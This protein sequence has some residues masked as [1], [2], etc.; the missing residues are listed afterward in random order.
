MALVS[1]LLTGCNGLS[2]M[3]SNAG[4][5]R[6][7]ANPNPV[8]T[9]DEKV[10][11]KFT[12]QVPQKYFD[13]G[14]VMFIQPVFSWEGGNIPLEPLTLKGEKVDGDGTIINYA[15]GGRFT[16]SDMFDF[17][18]GMETGRVTLTPVGYSAR[19]TNEDARFADDILRDNNGKEFSPVLISDGVNNT[20]SMVDIKGNISISPINYNKTQG[21]VEAADIYFNGGTSELDWNFA[22][23]Q[24]FDSYNTLQQLKRIMLEQ[25]LPKQISITGW[26]SPEGEET[27]NVGVSKNRADVA[28]AQLN[29]VLDE[30]LTIMA[31]RAKVKPQDVDYYKYEQLKKLVITTRAAGEDWVH[32]VVMVEASDI[33]DKHA[34][35]NIVET[36]Q[37]LVKREQMIRNMAEVYS[38]L[39]DEIFPSLRRAQIALY[40]SEARKTDAELAKLA[41]TKPEKLS[42]DELMYAAYINYNYDTKLKYYKW[43]TENHS[44]E[45]AAWN[46]AGAV[47][48]FLDDYE[49]AERYLKVARD[50]N[51]HNPDVLNNTGLLFL[52]KKDYALAKYYFEEAKRQGSNDADANIPILNL[53][54]GN[55]S[56]AQKA[57]KGNP[58]TY[59]LAFAQLMNDETGTAVRTLDCCLDQNADVKYLRAVCYARLGDK[60]NCLKN[61][62]ASVDD[63]YEYK[64][65]AAVDTEFKEYWDDPEFKLIIKLYN[66]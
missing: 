24:K 45:W 56:E 63:N 3:K 19:R 20:S 58:C 50:M 4:K 48:F 25:G 10:V 34:I 11:V 1:V 59:N 33:Q 16:Y 66:D 65:K 57:M 61:L 28:T 47:A 52:A 26:A 46:N 51:P 23:N 18:P 32:F 7:Q 31:R 14:C 38:E 22:M 49:E 2:K 9:M 53:K 43:A 6:Y 35:I 60:A 15:N 55:Y 44:S 27:D 39:N 12:G 62:K 64:R 5:V 42:F 41:S 54:R 8:E 17:K 29:K 40:Y 21:I 30:V 13:K 37:N 36:Q